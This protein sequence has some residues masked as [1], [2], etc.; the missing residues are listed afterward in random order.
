VF[1]GCLSAVLLHHTTTSWPTGLVRAVVCTH[2]LDVHA[3]LHRKGCHLVARA[4]LDFWKPLL[5][6]LL[7]APN[8]D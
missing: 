4:Q 7:L 8:V 5:L 3:H 6:A 2:T 1:N